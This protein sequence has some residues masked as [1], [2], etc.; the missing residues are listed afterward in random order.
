VIAR[1]RLGTGAVT[2]ELPAALATVALAAAPSAAERVLDPAAEA[3]ALGLEAPLVK[4]G[5]VVVVI[6]D[7]T[8][9]FPLV[10]TLPA[11]VHALLE[12]GV[13][14]GHVAI[15]VASGTHVAGAADVAPERLGALPQGITLVRHDP[16]GPMVDCGVTPAGTP[17]R[18]NA[19]LADAATVLCLGGTAFHYFAGFGGG[20]KMLFPGLG[21]RA[22]IAINHSRALAPWPP[23]GLADG[24]GPGRLTGNPVAEDLFALAQFLPTAF[25]LTLWPGS[26]PDTW[27]GARWSS[28]EEFASVCARYA[29]GR[30]VGP[31]RAFDVVFASAGGAPRDL[32]VVQSHKALFHAAQYVRSGGLLVYAA[33]IEEG[34]G[35]PALARR[36]AEA[37]GDRAALAQGARE[38][39]DLNA[40]TALS[41]A[42]IAAR[43][44]VLWIAGRREPLL[45]PWG[46][47]FAGRTAPLA[48]ELD[49]LLAAAERTL[50][51]AVIDAASEVLPADAQDLEPARPGA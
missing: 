45:E 28:L 8:R 7:R 49:T 5:R 25:H 33:A 38:R 51:A 43:V 17:V 6:P 26:V 3:R 42:A 30:R 50:R 21:A 37:P 35:S 10:E 4:G 24:V 1:L 11:L 13:S 18:V 40:Q 36:L 16:D 46:I 23:G 14:A 39:Y 29:A 27:H 19:V 34:I 2:L 31:A 32:D 12:R 48:G 20:P 41:L 47:R 44:R 22:S 15:A 9:P